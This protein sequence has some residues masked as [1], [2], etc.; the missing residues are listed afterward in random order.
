MSWILDASRWY[1]W[2][3]ITFTRVAI[4]ANAIVAFMPNR[5]ENT[6]GTGKIYQALASGVPSGL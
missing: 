6:Q 5:P 1:F 4:T 2:S 3:K